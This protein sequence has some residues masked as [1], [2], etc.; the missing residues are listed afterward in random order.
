MKQITYNEQDYQIF[1][2]SCF[3]QKKFYFFFENKEPDKSFEGNYKY[4]K[5]NLAIEGDEA[6]DSI[7]IQLKPGE[8]ALRVLK[9][10]EPDAECTISYK[11]TYVVADA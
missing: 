8:T 2:Y 1:F 4:T 6:A 11:Y 3:Y 7:T 10:I 5:K 9:P